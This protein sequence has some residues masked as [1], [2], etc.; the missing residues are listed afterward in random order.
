MLGE[1]MTT[2]LCAVAELSI[3]IV[4]ETTAGDP[5]NHGRLETLIG[6][7]FCISADLI[8]IVILPNIQIRVKGHHE[9]VAS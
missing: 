5:L 1:R 7:L 8:M 9:P 6:G 3:C 2:R 4:V